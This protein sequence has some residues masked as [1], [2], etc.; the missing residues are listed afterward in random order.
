MVLTF[1]DYQKITATQRK[2]VKRAKLQQ[3]IDEHVDADNAASIC[4]ILQDELKIQTQDIEKK[5]TAKFDKRIKDIEHENERL[6][7]ENFEVKS[8]VCEKK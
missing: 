6:K 3:L 8:A 7:K 2:H 1:E 4:V 5:L